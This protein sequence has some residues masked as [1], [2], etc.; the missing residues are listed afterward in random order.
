MLIIPKFDKK[1][2]IKTLLFKLEYHRLTT[3]IFDINQIN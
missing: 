2:S 1:I 3:Q